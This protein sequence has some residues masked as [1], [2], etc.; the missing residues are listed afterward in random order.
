[1]SEKLQSIELQLNG[2]SEALSILGTNDQF[3]RLI[4]DKLDV[5]IITRGENILVSGH[6]TAVTHV[7]KV[8]SALL[9]LYE[10]GIEVTE[11]DVV[12]A[13]DLAVQGKINQLQTLFADEIIKNDRGQSIRVK[14][15]GQRDYVSAMKKNDLVFCIGPAGTG[16][17]FLA[18]VQAVY[19]LKNGDV[20]KIILTRPAVEA[21]ESLGFLPGDLKEKVDPYLRP[22]Y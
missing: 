18:V 11:R 22:L 3:L 12:Y 8:L 17:T 5:S 1:M 10:K 9:S 21:G 4:E 6:N 7:K 20:R 15:L 19:S 14:T 2:P 13:I 16:K